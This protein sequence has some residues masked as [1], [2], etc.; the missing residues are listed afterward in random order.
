MSDKHPNSKIVAIMRCPSYLDA[1]QT[2][3][4]EFMSLS[5][6]SVGSYWKSVSAQIVGSGLTYDEQELLMPHL[7]DTEPTDRDFRKKCKEFFEGLITNI[8]H[9]LGR[10]FEVGLTGDNKKPVGA[11]VEIDGVK[12]TNLPIDMMDFVRFRHAK[13]HP[14]TAA[15]KDLAT[16]DSLK[17]FYVY[18]PEIEETS[19]VATT[20]LQDT[21]LQTYLTI[22]DDAAK[23]SQLLTLLGTDPRDFSG[24][25]APAQ[26][27]QRLKELATENPAEF[28]KVYKIDNFE[29]RFKIKSLINVGIFKTVGERIFEAAGNRLIAN[30]IE[31][32]I[33][34]MQTDE[35]TESLTMW[36]ASYQD[37]V[38]KPKASVRR[39]VIS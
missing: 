3:A 21:A 7:I 37:I 17:L 6:Q 25:N 11:K 28:E 36:M 5:R 19:K 35:Y 9:G 32:T 27:Q 14:L 18:D 39:R 4:K 12:I 15:S 30:S 22:K 34:L 10:D 23:V 1:V 16:G 8:P 29:L 20:L 31:D 13:D 26:R 33:K 38:A 24:I 2:G